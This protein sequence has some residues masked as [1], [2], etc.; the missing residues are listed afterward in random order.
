MATA[1][2][3]S[4]SGVRTTTFTELSVRKQVLCNATERCTTL[5]IGKGGRSM[6]YL[7]QVLCAV[8]F[9]GYETTEQMVT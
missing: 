5:H 8:R 6:T 7:P 9:D 2:T 3:E 1:E 4:R